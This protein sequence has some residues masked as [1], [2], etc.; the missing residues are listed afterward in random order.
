M[1][2]DTIETIL[3]SLVRGLALDSS[4]RV[5]WRC[6]VIVSVRPEVLLYFLVIPVLEMPLED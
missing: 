6:V 5:L 2:E 1:E 4:V 3:V